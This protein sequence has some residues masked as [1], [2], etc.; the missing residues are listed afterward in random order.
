MIIGLVLLSLVAVMIFFGL[1][2]KF[3]EKIGVASW[4]AFILVLA[5]VLGAVLPTIK[6]G[7]A[8]QM[9]IGGFIVPLILAVLLMFMIG[10]GSD[11]ARTFIAIL[12]IASVAVSTR[13]LLAPTN[14]GMEILSS[15]IIGVAGA[16]VACIIAKSKISILSAAIGGVVLGDIIVGLVYGFATSNTAG[17][18]LLGAFGT[19]DAIIISAVLAVSLSYVID[20]IRRRGAESGIS[21]STLSTEAGQDNVFKVGNMYITDSSQPPVEDSDGFEDYFDDDI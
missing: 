11:L 9:S 10:A 7:V 15:V 17:A 20:M 12:A 6:M 13:M 2:N 16:I 14:T 5:L 3:F 4:L 1:T 18:V 21:R 8:F 19:F